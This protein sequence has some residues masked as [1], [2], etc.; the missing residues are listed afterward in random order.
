MHF[1][2]KHV[3]LVKNSGTVQLEGTMFLWRVTVSF[4][5]KKRLP[6]AT[7]NTIHQLLLVS[8]EQILKKM[9]KLSLEEWTVSLLQY[10]KVFIFLLFPTLHSW[11][12]GLGAVA[13]IRSQGTSV[14]TLNNGFWH[15]RKLNSATFC[16][17][18][19][20]VILDLSQMLNFNLPLPCYSLATALVNITHSSCYPK[21]WKKSQIPP[22]AY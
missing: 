18:L 22:L 10:H 3:I 16:Q 21:H 19:V 7:P 1:F 14:V 2:L 5:K 13:L 17:N 8:K 4:Q 12:T 9:L 15:R 11:G 6:L 20:Q